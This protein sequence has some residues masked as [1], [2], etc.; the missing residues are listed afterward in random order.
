MSSVKQAASSKQRFATEPNLSRGKAHLSSRDN[1]PGATQKQI[2]QLPPIVKPYE[3]VGYRRAT[4]MLPIP[5]VGKKVSVL[6]HSQRQHLD[7]GSLPWG[8][9]ED[10]GQL[11]CLMPTIS[12]LAC[13]SEPGLIRNTGTA[14]SFAS[15]SLSRQDLF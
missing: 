2:A 1:K 5:D 10:A 12:L 11:G 14:P 4:D 9:V 8:R 7:A 6:R 13:T 3:A 15:V